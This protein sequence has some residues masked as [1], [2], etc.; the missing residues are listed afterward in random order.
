M[1]WKHG[2]YADSGYT[3][4]YYVE[5]MPLRLHWAALIQG[6]LTPTHRF[7]YVDVGC[8]QGFNLILAA[9]AHPDSEFIGIDFMPSHI[10][11]ARDLAARCGLSNIT[12]IEADFVTLA[13]DQATV[14][15]LGE[16]DYVV[17]HGIST[18][19]SQKVKK[20]LFTLV[21]SILK[22]GGLFYNSYNTLPGWLNMAPFQHLVRLLQQNNSGLEAITKAQSL[23]DTLVKFS[24]LGQHFP[25][26]KERV[27]SLMELDPT[28]LVQELNNH[29]WE[30]VFVSQM[31]DDLALVKLDYLGTATLSEIFLDTLPPE[32]A[33]LLE[34]ITDPKLKL[35]MR[36]YAVYKSFRRDLYVKGILPVWREQLREQIL[37][38]RFVADP[39]VK[40]PEVDQ[41]YR[42]SSGLV[43][44]DGNYELCSAIVQQMDV[45]G[46]LSLRELNRL[47]KEF[48]YSSLS[49]M[50]SLLLSGG[51]LRFYKDVDFSSSVNKGISNAVIQGAPY[52]CLS[53]PRAGSAI[54]L[55]DLEI[56][57][58]NACF[59]AIPQR[60][61]P[62]FVSGVL[63]GLGGALMKEGE[64]IAD[65][66]MSLELLEAEMEIFKKHIPWLV[67][68]GV[69]PE[70]SL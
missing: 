30:P 58:A 61:W 27:G 22:P 35:Q 37:N 47:N 54:Y 38:T 62:S 1:N 6:Q 13:S 9:A 50:A 14:K 70:L 15:S 57:F 65:P 18:W 33:I 21:G 45:P 36:D 41:G 51:W 40:R 5:A 67:A 31:I 55:R 28:Y 7:R 49:K 4:G 29:F 48:S 19:I 59:Q 2:Y 63:H 3:Y 16:F 26:L 10:A 34:N 24:P 42:F 20:S 52:H 32:I 60:E 11:H 8:G 69:L 23:M 56:M 25:T 64:K 66:K 53:A 43:E 46:G 17:C 12:F 39:M 68:M 44:V